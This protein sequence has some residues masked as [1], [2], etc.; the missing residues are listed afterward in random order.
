MLR[1]TFKWFFKSHDIHWFP[2]ESEL[3]AQTV[4]RFKRTIKE[5]LLHYFTHNNTKRCIDVLP[6]F[7]YSY[8][9]SCHRFIKMKQIE[10][11]KK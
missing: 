9:N 7:V 1:K 8:N 4:D 2:Y 6:S 11:I 5:R 10:G 3:K